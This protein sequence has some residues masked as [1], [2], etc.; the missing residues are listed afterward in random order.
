MS[1]GAK[2]CHG[3]QM[4]ISRSAWIHISLAIIIAIAALFLIRMHNAGGSYLSI[5]SELTSPAAA[6][7]SASIARSEMR[8]GVARSAD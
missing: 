5:G 6:G 7:A 2:R 1:F 3:E 8:G 4:K